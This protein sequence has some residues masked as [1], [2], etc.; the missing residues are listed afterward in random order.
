MTQGPLSGGD[1]LLVGY[2]AVFALAALACG[3]GLL[4]ARRI[5]DRDTR[6]GLLGLLSTSG[7]WALAQAGVFL[8]P[9]A[10]LK[11]AFYL[12]GLVVGLSTV[13]PWLYFC[14]AY[15][16]RSLHRN[17][18]YQGLA[19]GIFALITLV[20]LT[21]PWHGLYFTTAPVIEPFPHLA[22]RPGILHWLAMGLAYALAAV[23]YFML[24][25]LFRSVGHETRSLGVLVGITGLPVL[26]G[27]VGLKSPTVLALNYEPIGVA[28]F[29]VGV[30]FVF[31]T[32]FESVRLAGSREQPVVVLDESDRIREYN[33]AARR[34]FPALGDGDAVGSPLH[35]TLPDVASALGTEGEV[36]PVENG[37]TTRYY[38]VATN[39]ISADPGQLGRLVLFTDIT[40]RE[41]Y[42]RELE[43]QN[44]RLERFASVVS[45]DLRNPLSVAKGHLDMAREDGDGESLGTVADALDR[46]ETLIEDLLALARQ[47]Q[48]ADET[49]PVALGP[50]L[51]ESWNVVAA[52]EAD[53]IVEGEATVLADPDRLRQLLENVIRNAVEHGGADVTIRAGA[54][55][56]GF[57]LEDDGPGI[58]E[59]EREAA[60]EWGYSTENDGTGFGLAIV[61]AIADA[62]GWELSVT[63]A[64]AGGA[65]FEVTG[66]D[67]E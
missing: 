50:L 67:R 53:L 66:V 15:T 57:Y 23:G 16:G 42:R 59:D 32:R 38:R 60:L 62:H 4:G 39:P 5:E 29:A 6:R 48:T 41:Q 54:L 35:T 56:G 31:L 51:E 40:E 49:E 1:L 21:N 2:V 65:R 36:L 13:G 61:D 9:G 14:S 46:M 47:G 11:W 18:T 64:E 20:K 58:P 52:P 24:F 7:V 3:I 44:E 33:A 45:H 25:E 19:V 63:A 12:L 28:A 37:A 27:A 30:L 10:D 43:R 17:R 22:I 8:V 26:L 55:E 34:L